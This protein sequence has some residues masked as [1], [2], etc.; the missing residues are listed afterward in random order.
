MAD[1]HLAKKLDQYAENIALLPVKV[2]SKILRL[3]NSSGD[4]GFM[5]IGSIV[6]V[7]ITS[8]ITLPMVLLAN[9]LKKR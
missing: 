2:M 5:A 9:K 1:N 6:S 4:L 3:G 7:V 8:P